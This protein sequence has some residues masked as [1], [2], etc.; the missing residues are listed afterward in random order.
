[1]R[2]C[3]I[4]YSFLI[5]NDFCLFQSVTKVKLIFQV[6][7]MLIAHYPDNLVDLMLHKQNIYTHS[8]TKFIH[9]S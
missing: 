3:F 2:A 1:M 8:I 9:S 4:H 7:S 5:Y 6:E